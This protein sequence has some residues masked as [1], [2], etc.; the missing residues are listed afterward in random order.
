MVMECG[1]TEDRKDGEESSVCFVGISKTFPTKDDSFLRIANLRRR[2]VDKALMTQIRPGNHAQT[3]TVTWMMILNMLI[4]SISIYTLI[5]T[6]SEID[7][8]FFG[9]KEHICYFA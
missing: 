9:E 6:R 1:R 5:Q 3:D 7:I 4:I 2:I 8:C